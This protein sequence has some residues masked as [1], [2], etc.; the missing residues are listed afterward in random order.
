MLDRTVRAANLT[1]ES[2]AFGG[3]GA[4]HATT[5]T[6]DGGDAESD[7]QAINETGSVVL[8]ARAEG[9]DAGDGYSG[10][11]G[12]PGAGGD[13]VVRAFGQTHGDA[14]VVLIGDGWINKAVGPRSMVVMPVSWQHAQAPSFDVVNGQRAPVDPLNLICSLQ[15]LTWGMPPASCRL[16]AT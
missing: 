13:A 9:G 14:D 2:G 4:G 1:L 11:S 6:L 3:N 10:G 12:L 5:G 7:A 15:A 8:R 16:V